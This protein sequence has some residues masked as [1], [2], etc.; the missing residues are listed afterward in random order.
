LSPKN[1]KSGKNRDGG[2]FCALLPSLLCKNALLLARLYRYDGSMRRAVFIEPMECL[3]AD[4][5]PEGPGW[6]YEI[7]LD[8]YRMIAVR[9]KP[10]IYSRLKNS[11]TS[12]FPEI[13]AALTSLA[14]GT[15]LDG[16][17]V[18]LNAEGKP[19]F[20]LLQNFRSAEAFIVYFVFDILAHQ[21][22]SLLELPLVERRKILCAAVESSDRVQI[23]E[24][25]KSAEDI[26]RFVKANHLE[27]VIAKR[28]D[29]VY[30]PGK[31]TGLW[32]KIRINQT[33]E[34]VIGGYTPSHLGLD[35]ILV[36]F[37]SGKDL[38]FAS[39]VRAGFSPV[40]RRQVH[41][42]IRS[43]ETGKCPFVN[44]PQPSAG[45]WGQGITEQAMKDMVWLNPE[46]VAQIEF[47]QWTGDNILRSASFVRLR[48]DKNP[49]KVV[50]ET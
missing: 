29:S 34:F 27:G 48:D 47:L 32:V 18:A 38:L 8:G 40:T 33:Q 43:L 9:G 11:N 22:R 41:Q 5:V 3:A 42:K 16:E 19:D 2:E 1:V 15:V 14:E 36:G 17:L 46:A 25:S 44:L 45:R 23:V 6:L 30:L 49:R 37:Y 12:K 4:K 35:A 13:A 28:D 7:K 10:E 39:R 24:V 50:R 20:N 31:R 21:G 26:V